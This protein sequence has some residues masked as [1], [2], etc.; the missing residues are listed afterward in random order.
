MKSRT[1]HPL[2]ASPV[3]RIVNDGKGF[4]FLREK[5]FLERKEKKLWQ[6][7]LECLVVN[8]NTNI[9]SVFARVTL[10]QLELKEN[11]DFEDSSVSEETVDIHS[12][13]LYIRFL[14]NFLPRGPYL[15]SSYMFLSNMQPCMCKCQLIGC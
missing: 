3:L 8:S 12:N 7:V 2:V 5:H 10:L 1:L 15:L 9:I 11:M 4:N 14:C 13:N 6:D